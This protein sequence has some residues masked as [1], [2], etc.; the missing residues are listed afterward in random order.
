[1][2]SIGLLLI[3]LATVAGQMDRQ[4]P[5]KTAISTCLQYQILERPCARY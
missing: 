2:R 1:M 3:A 5:M 4:M